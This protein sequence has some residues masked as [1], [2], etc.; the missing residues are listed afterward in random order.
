M[1]D[2]KQISLVWPVKNINIELFLLA[3]LIPFLRYVL[4]FPAYVDFFYILYG[5]HILLKRKNTLELMVASLILF[6]LTL[7]LIILN[8]KDFAEVLITN[9]YYLLIIS[10][11]VILVKF[12]MESKQYAKNKKN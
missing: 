2:K 1:A 11:I 3:L 6:I 10:V 7:F 8:K 12:L 9:V 4:N 5:F